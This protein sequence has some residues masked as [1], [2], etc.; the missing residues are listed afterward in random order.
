MYICEDC[1]AVFEEPS[2]YEDHHPYG[3]TYAVEEWAEC[4]K[5]GGSFDEAV[6]CPRCWEYV[7]KLTDGVCE[8]CY[9]EMNE[10]V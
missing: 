10:E 8:E 7:T 9:K 3:M 1:G 2:V 4:P 5:C 6:Q